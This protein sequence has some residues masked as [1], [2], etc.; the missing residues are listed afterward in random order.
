MFLP[1]QFFKYKD[2]YLTENF[3]YLLFS[4]GSL[5]AI[6]KIR[7]PYVVTIVMNVCSA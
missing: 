4:S 6:K 3:T 2:S 7:E 1:G 5:T